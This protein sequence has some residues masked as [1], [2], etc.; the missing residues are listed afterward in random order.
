MGCGGGGGGCTLEYKWLFKHLTQ[1]V[2]LAQLYKEVP[3]SLSVALGLFVFIDPPPTSTD[4][5]TTSRCHP[6]PPLLNIRGSVGGLAE[7][8]QEERDG[9]KGREG[10]RKGC[11]EGGG[12]MVVQTG[13][14]VGMMGKKAGQAGGGQP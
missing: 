13:G 8:E 1:S 2:S 5:P 9:S 4:S 11:R 3:S 6:P 12:D 14:R 7:P 10:W